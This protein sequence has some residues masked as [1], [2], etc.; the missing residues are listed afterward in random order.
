MEQGQAFQHRL[1]PAVYGFPVLS[2][3]IPP[4][5]KLFRIESCQPGVKILTACAEVGVRAAVDTSVSTR[6]TLKYAYIKALYK[7]LHSKHTLSCVIACIYSVLR[8]LSMAITLWHFQACTCLRPCILQHYLLITSLGRAR[9]N[10][11][12]VTDPRC[13]HR[14]S[15]HVSPKAQTE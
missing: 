9:C 10:G 1:H 8:E 11:Q 3:D 5:G 7:S 13:K 15:P 14:V 12:A 4:R 6:P 2:V